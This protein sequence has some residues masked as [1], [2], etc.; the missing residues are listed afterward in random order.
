MSSAARLKGHNFERTIVNKLKDEL[1]VECKRVLDQYREGNL[2]DIILDPF[3]IEC[4]RYASKPDA[5]KAWWDQAWQAGQHMNLTPVLVWKFDRRPIQA[6][7]PLSLLADNYPHNKSYTAQVSWE[8]LVMILREEIDGDK[9]VQP[10][11]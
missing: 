6:M 7:V 11:S 2:G 9:N 10:A 1:G 5:P 8:N 4:K 3:V